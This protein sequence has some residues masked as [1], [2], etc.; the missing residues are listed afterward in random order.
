MRVVSLSAMSGSEYGAV[1]SPDGRQVAFAWNGE[2]PNADSRAWWQGSWDVYVKLVGAS[3]LRRLT[4]DPGVDLAP[5]WSPDG[6]QIAYVRLDGPLPQIR[7]VSSLGGSDRQVSDFPIL[8]PVTWSPDGR[9]VVAGRVG[10]SDS[11]GAT[12]G[13]YLVPVQGG[14]PRAITRPKASGQDLSPVF[15][16]DG[17]RLAYVSCPG[18]GPDSDCHV[19]VMNLDSAFTAVGSPRRLAGPPFPGGRSSLTWSRDG[20][21]VIFNATEN[22]LEYL[23]R[24]G[25]EGESTPER[26]EQAGL[27][28]FWPATSS[29]GD[30]LAFTRMSHD[31][32]VYRFEPG[33]SA[34]PV[35]PSS[36]FDGM[37]QFSPDGRRIA[38]CSL[39]SGDAMQVWVANADGSSPAQLTHGP[40]RF[41]GAPSWSPDGRRIAFESAGERPHIWTVDG[42]GGT[43]RQLTNDPGDQMTPT[44]SRDGEWIYF[45]WSQA[46]ND[47][48]I[49]RTRVSNGTKERVTRGGGFVAS[50]SV[51]G[52]TLLYTSKVY[53]FAAHGAAACRRR[54]PTDH[55]LCG[56]RR[57]CR[58]PE[59]HLLHPVFG[60]S[61]SR[62]ESA[63]APDES[64]H[65]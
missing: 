23:W 49:W 47:R 42:E 16:P 14:E 24:V 22:Q 38:F 25:V 31:E 15:S 4:T 64:G 5:A 1:F 40:G 27:N 30:R 2:I 3:D 32:D 12:N 35:A 10:A 52:R 13:I 51:D 50:E 43:P 8:L 18:P 62:P 7:V 26:L 54:A 19:Q 11:A 21:F 60:H 65:R 59:G 48:D 36:V 33:R 17:H 44:W 45:S 55:R 6:R 61:H 20:R 46:P 9:Y 39:R 53:R 28:A 63:R 37:P 34:Q 29:T 41:Q 56:R 58:S 57:V